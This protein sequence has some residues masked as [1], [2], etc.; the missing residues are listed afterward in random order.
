[1]LLKLVLLKQKHPK[2]YKK[3]KIINNKIY[4]RIYLVLQCSLNL[5]H[6]GIINKMTKI[7]TLIKLNRII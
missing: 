1:M 4:N 2:S 5:L 6:T 3:T 7:S